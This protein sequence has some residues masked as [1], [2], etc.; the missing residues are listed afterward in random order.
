MLQDQYYSRISDR[1]KTLGCKCLVKQSTSQ[2]LHGA[3]RRYKARCSQRLHHVESAY[4][5]ITRK[6]IKNCTERMDIIMQKKLCLKKPQGKSL[7]CK[8]LLC[9]SGKIVVDFLFS[10]MLFRNCPPILQELLV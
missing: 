5:I 1:K 6:K 10:L 8:Y 3:L 7:K 4:D 2:F 9:M